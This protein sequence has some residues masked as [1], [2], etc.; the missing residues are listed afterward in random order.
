MEICEATWITHHSNDCV[1]LFLNETLRATCRGSSGT[2][3]LNPSRGTASLR[4]T[5]QQPQ[6]CSTAMHRIGEEA[7]AS[8]FAM[9]PDANS[10][11]SKHLSSNQKV[12]E[13]SQPPTFKRNP[14][15][16]TGTAIAVQAPGGASPSRLQPEQLLLRRAHRSRAARISSRAAADMPIR[17]TRT[18]CPVFAKIY[19]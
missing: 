4:A 18:S 10:L 19:F 16:C 1:F 11:Y 2:W 9:T 17:R 6:R 12:Q 5:L 13:C 15:R 7:L 14:S 8:L 3:Q